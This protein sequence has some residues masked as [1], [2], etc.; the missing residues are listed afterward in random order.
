MDRL[1]YARG[2]LEASGQ[3]KL[4]RHALYSLLHKI[5]HCAFRTS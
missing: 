4:S 5:S 3:T 2:R 1:G